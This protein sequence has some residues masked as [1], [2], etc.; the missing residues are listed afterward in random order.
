LCHRLPLSIVYTQHKRAEQELVIK[1]FG[2]AIAPPSYIYG[3]TILGDCSLIRVV[4]GTTLL[5]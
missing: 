5:S 3:C 2:I 1:P 4:D